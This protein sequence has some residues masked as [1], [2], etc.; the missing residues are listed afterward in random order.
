MLTQEKLNDPSASFMQTMI[1]L[2]LTDEVTPYSGRK[3]VE[4]LP[5]LETIVLGLM[6]LEKTYNSR[7]FDNRLRFK[8]RSF[9]TR[10]CGI[11]TEVG[12]LG[13]VARGY[14]R[15][16]SKR[17]ERAINERN[18]RVWGLGDVP[19]VVTAKGAR[20]IGYLVAN[21]RGGLYKDV[22]KELQAESREA[23]KGWRADVPVSMLG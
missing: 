22:V 7:H 16:A 17:A 9:S 23:A 19:F 3:E 14:L 1:S 15:P 5:P 21:L 13:L 6:C 12:I 11:F 10:E 18:D 4:A 20:R 2:F 8:Y